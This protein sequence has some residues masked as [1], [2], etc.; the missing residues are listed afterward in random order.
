M[1]LKRFFFI[2]THAN[3]MYQN[4]TINYGVKRI[5]LPG[6]VLTN[7]FKELVSNRV[8]NMMDETC[9]MDNV[10]ENF[11]FVFLDVTHNLEVARKPGNEN[12]IRRAYVFLDDGK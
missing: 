6:K 9:I 12:L 11:C 5:D 1:G 7:Y 3:P 4:F 8:V 10:K 2:F